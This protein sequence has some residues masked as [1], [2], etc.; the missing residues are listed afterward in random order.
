[1]DENLLKEAAELD[2][3]SLDSLQSQVQMAK[4]K[5]VLKQ[6]HYAISQLPNGQFQTYLI[7]PLTGKRK[8][9]RAI[10]KERVEDRIYQ[11]VTE[12]EK[13]KHNDNFTMTDLYNEWLNYKMA[14]TESSNT[15]R[16]HR[17]HYRKYFENTELFGTTVSAVDHLSLQA[18]CNELVKKNGM[19]AKEWTNVKTILK[20][21]FEFAYDKH[22]ITINPMERVRITV[23]FKQVKKKTG[24]T[25]TYNTEELNELREYLEE[26]FAETSD[27]IFLAIELNFLIG[28]RVGDLVALRWSDWVDMRHLH[29]QREEVHNQDNGQ[30]IVVEHTK[31]NQDRFVP[32]VP[33]ALR[34]LNRI[35]EHR[36]LSEFM[37]TRE[38]TR[39]TSRQVAYVLQKYAYKKGVCVKSSHKMRKTFASNLNANGVP[40]DEIREI[41]GHSS[42]STTLNYL[43]NPLTEEETYERIKSA[44]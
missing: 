15:I 10:S 1:M 25:E 37:F 7:D 26:Q 42:L 12:F 18:Y 22:Y 9:I 17:Q 40:I 41:L 21:M 33:K 39:I 20:G 11:L 2:I 19:T 27:T 23:R 4:K 29:I 34:L 3:I 31:T 14:I 5:A 24:K 6:H 28:L 35:N 44:L 43:F 13:A 36:D 32:L 16:R 38:G 8:E 30:F